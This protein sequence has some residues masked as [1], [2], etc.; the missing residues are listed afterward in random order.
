[1]VKGWAIVI[2]ACWTCLAQKYPQ[3]PTEVEAELESQL[4][5]LVER[6]AAP[7]EIDRAPERPSGESIS[8][9]GLRHKVPKAA[10][11]SFERAMKSSKSRDHVGAAAALQAAVQIDPLFAAAYNQLGAE[12]GWMGR[13]EEAKPAFERAVELDPNSWSAQYNLALVLFQLGDPAGA[14]QHARRSLEFGSQ[15]A[16]AHWLLGYVLYRGDSTR[17][18]ALRHVRYAARTLKEAKQFLAM[19]GQ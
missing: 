8:V 12:Y 7:M 5:G 10:Q 3:T 2:L 9:Y 1:M 11:K 4:R 19:A 14:E 15:S 18:E 13:F 6:R 17:D 16:L